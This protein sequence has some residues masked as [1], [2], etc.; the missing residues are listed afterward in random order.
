MKLVTVKLLKPG[1]LKTIRYPGELL[2]VQPG[3]VLIRAIWERPN[4]ELGY[5]TFETGDHFYEY[6]YT[7]RWFNIFAIF[8][9]SGVLRGWYCNVTRPAVYRDDVIESEDLEID[10]FV[11]PDRQTMLRLDLDEFEARNFAQ[12][13]PE[14]YRE[15]Y[16]ALEELEEMVRRGEAPFDR[17]ELVG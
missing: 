5:V 6:F 9:A 10:L 3:F 12:T 17:T 1:K 4:A 11:S 16:A 13:E 14:T 2:E 8:S 7:D 15:A